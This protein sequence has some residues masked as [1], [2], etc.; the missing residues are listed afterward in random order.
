MKYLLPIV[1]ALLARYQSPTIR[2]TLAEAGQAVSSP[3]TGDPI[4]FGIGIGV[5][6]LTIVG[7]VLTLTAHFSK[8]KETK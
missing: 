2:Q 3:T 5:I 4:G 8:P 1:T 6:A 7:L